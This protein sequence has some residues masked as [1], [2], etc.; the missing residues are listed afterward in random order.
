MGSA[1]D[2]QDECEKDASASG[3]A[4]RLLFAHRF[5][6]WNRDGVGDKWLSAVV[7]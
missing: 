4:G 5:S 6:L 7:L 3:G 2:R 1:A